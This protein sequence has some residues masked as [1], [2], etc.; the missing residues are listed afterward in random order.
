MSV[1][2]GSI[3]AMNLAIVA[4]LPV[5]SAIGIAL[6][7]MVF[8]FARTAGRARALEARERVS[9]ISLPRLTGSALP[10]KLSAPALPT[11]AGVASYWQ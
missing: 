8:V 5:L 1:R 7:V 6:T 9:W 10:C 2:G 11:R 4:V 3:G